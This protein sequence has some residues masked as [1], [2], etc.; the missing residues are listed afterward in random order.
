MGKEPETVSAT[1]AGQISADFVVVDGML[2][3]RRWVNEDGTMK[4]GRE[5]QLALMQVELED[6]TRRLQRITRE[7]NS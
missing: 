6:I 1:Q 7:L 3:H 5:L 2:V 4:T